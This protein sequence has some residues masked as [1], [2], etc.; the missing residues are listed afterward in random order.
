MS[1]QMRRYLRAQMTG[2]CCQPVGL[3]IVGTAATAATASLCL[4]YYYNVGPESCD[5]WTGRKW[6]IGSDPT[7]NLFKIVFFS[8]LKYCP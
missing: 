7:F 3:G 6:L 8:T 4:I 5:V 1:D 2:V